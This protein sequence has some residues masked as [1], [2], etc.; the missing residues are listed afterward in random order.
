MKKLSKRAKKQKKWRSPPCESE[1]Q[2]TG[3]VTTKSTNGGVAK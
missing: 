3:L 2:L 1:T